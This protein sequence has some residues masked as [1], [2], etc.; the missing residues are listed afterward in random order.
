MNIMKAKNVIKIVK[1]YADMTFYKRL[2]NLMLVFK[3]Y[4]KFFPAN[5]INRF[6]SRTVVIVLKTN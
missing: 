2:R 3:F 4:E 6:K 1:M 5:I